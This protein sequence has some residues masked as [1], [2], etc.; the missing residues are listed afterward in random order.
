MLSG[1]CRELTKGLPGS[2]SGARQEFARRMLRVRRM[3]SRAPRRLIERMPRVH[4]EFAEKS[5][6]DRTMKIIRSSKVCQAIEPPRHSL[7]NC[8][9]TVPPE[10]RVANVKSMHRVDAF[11]NSPGVCRKL[12]KGIG[13]LLGWH[14]GVRQKKIETHRKIIGGSRKACRESGCSNDV[15]GSRW[16][17]TSR[18]V[19]GIGKLARNVKG[20]HR[21]EDQRTYRKIAR[22][23]RSMREYSWIFAPVL[24]PIGAL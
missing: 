12:A 20:D 4:Q 13:S 10:N 21:K 15:V 11:G 19:E 16:K 6:D 2:S 5:I 1:P 18:F 7:P 8:Q 23:C 3:K 17:F 22:G 14:K 24:K 9:A